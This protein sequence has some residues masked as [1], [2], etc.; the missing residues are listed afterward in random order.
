[1]SRRYQQRVQQNMSLMLR[2]RHARE[3]RVTRCVMF[4]RG[5][6]YTAAV[7]TATRSLTPLNHKYS[8]KNGALYKQSQM[9]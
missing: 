2:R 8:I 9:H 6:R 1:M 5:Q 7:A 3:A 4:F